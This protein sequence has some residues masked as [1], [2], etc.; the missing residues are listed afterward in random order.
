MFLRIISFYSR[1]SIFILN[2]FSFVSRYKL[3]TYFL[4][5]C[6]EFVWCALV[7]MIHRA[8]LTIILFYHPTLCRTIFGIIDGKI[9]RCSIKKGK[10]LFKLTRFKKRLPFSIE[11]RPYAFVRIMRINAYA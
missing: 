1:C 8:K 7:H 2:L 10:S 5:G 4:K 9:W 11:Q 3:N 6:Y